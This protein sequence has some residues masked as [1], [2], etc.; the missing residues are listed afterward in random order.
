MNAGIIQLKKMHTLNKLI[1]KQSI[2]FYLEAQRHR[3]EVR[4]DP[5][6]YREFIHNQYKNVKEMIEKD[7]RPEV[8]KNIRMQELNLEQYNVT[9]VQQ[10]IVGILNM[11]RIAIEE[12]SNDIRRYLTMQ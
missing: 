4:H 8:L 10:W 6:K 1:L 9:Y 5:G 12:K 2:T 11:R 7:N 3:N